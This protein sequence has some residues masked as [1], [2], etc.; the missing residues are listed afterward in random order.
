VSVHFRLLPSVLSVLA[1]ASLLGACADGDARRVI[2]S[3]VSDLEVATSL[4]GVPWPAIPDDGVVRGVITPAG[5][6]VPALSEVEGGYVVVTPC[7]N[8]ATVTGTPLTGAHVVLDP[9]HGGS[10]PGAVSPDGSLRESD[11]NLVIAQRAA[12][13]LRQ[14]GAVVVL[15]RETDV[16]VTVSSRALLATTLRPAAFISIHHNAEP[17]GPSGTPGS[18]V[19]F[20]IG[21]AE[22]RRLAGLLHEEL[23]RAFSR[24]QVTWSADAGAGALARVDVDDG[25]NWYGVLRESVA[26]PAV[27]SEAAFISSPTE[28]ALLATPEFQQAEADA[29]TRAVVRF[30]GTTDPGSGFAADRT[31]GSSGGGGGADGC[32]DPDL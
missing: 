26:V 3:A 17:E 2:P 16:R 31:G 20:Q 6:T 11:V 5:F 29:I 30:V 9:G 8:E 4:A 21:S 22:S 15:T 19:Y 14:L 28:A 27:L 25:S 10:E 24:F 23:I 7:G 18:E 12:E 13:T 1:A 32:V